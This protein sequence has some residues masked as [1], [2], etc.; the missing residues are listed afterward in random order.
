VEARLKV[1]NCDGIGAAYWLYGGTYGGFYEIDVF[2]TNGKFPFTLA[3][4]I[5]F[6][7]DYEHNE[8][9]VS[10]EHRICDLNGERVVV[11][12][13]FITY[14]VEIT[15]Q[16]IDMY[17]NGVNYQ[18]NYFGGNGGQPTS[19]YNHPAIP[20]NLRFSVGG[21]P[22][23]GGPMPW[24]CYSLPAYYDIDYVRV[25]KR[26][27]HRAVTFRGGTGA[28]EFCTNGYGA[29]V[30]VDYYPGVTYQWEATPY[31]NFTINPNGLNTCNCERW[32]VTPNPGIA[33]GLYQ[34]KLTSIFPCGGSEVLPLTIKVVGAP[35]PSPTKI[36]LSTDDHQYFY[37]SVRIGK[38]AS[39]YEWSN[40]GGNS[41]NEGYHDP[42]S[43]QNIMVRPTGGDTWSEYL[44]A[45]KKYV[46]GFA[47]VLPSAECAHWRMSQL[48]K[49]TLAASRCLGRAN[50]QFRTLS[51]KSDKNAQISGLRMELRPVL[52]V[53]IGK[54]IG[55][56]V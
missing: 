5:H 10:H 14:G 35:P 55:E 2:E 47:A 56:S 43:G 39:A 44:R 21:A 42:V 31:F 6:G 36:S 29:N 12:D 9:N 8:G 4:N 40:D 33:P 23:M 32:W 38:L 25:Y 22:V 18:T 53:Q 16:Q 41:W 49:H 17:A 26:N 20:F 1:P 13:Q 7:A 45:G 50:S 48:P 54:H 51:L 3:S 15:D 46:R 34:V 52:L 19:V 37:P 30:S 28:I 24:D 11:G 27:T